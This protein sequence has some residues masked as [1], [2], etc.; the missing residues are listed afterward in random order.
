MIS[1]SYV[2]KRLPA[3]ASFEDSLRLLPEARD[4]LTKEYE[5]L[6]KMYDFQESFCLRGCAGCDEAG[7]GPLAG[8]VSAAAVVLEGRPWLPGLNDSKKISEGDREIIA[9]WI[10]ARA[11]AR[12]VAALSTD[13]IEAFNIR[14]AALEGMRRSLL[15]IAERQEINMALIDG[16]AVIPGLPLPQRAVIKGDARLPC[17]A[18]ASILAKV[19]R[20][21]I[22]REIDKSF[23]QYGFAANKCYGTAEHLQA[24]KKYGP[25]PWHRRSFGPVKKLLPESA[26]GETS[27]E[28]EGQAELF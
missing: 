5:R 24:L 9:L 3:A 6:Q 8:P 13:E 25:C 21:H 26:A 14:G 4:W 20:D 11:A 18:A 10:E 27:S 19:S 7:R 2:L 22:M 28:Q 15:A 12:H 23:P 17:I 16:N 1:L